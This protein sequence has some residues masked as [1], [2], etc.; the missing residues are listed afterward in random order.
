MS[1]ARYDGSTLG[2]NFQRPFI[3]KFAA[4]RAQKAALG[5]KY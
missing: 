1:R 3:V 2:E 5:I 4:P